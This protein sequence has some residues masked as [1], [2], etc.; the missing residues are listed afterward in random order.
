MLGFLECVFIFCFCIERPRQSDCIYEPHSTDK[1]SGVSR[2]L[3]AHTGTSTLE[4]L[5][6][7][8]ELASCA[9]S[10]LAFSSLFS[11]FLF[12]KTDPRG[13]HLGLETLRRWGKERGDMCDILPAAPYSSH[14]FLL[15]PS[16]L[17]LLSSF[18]KA[19]W[20]SCRQHYHTDQHNPT[21]LSGNVLYLF[22]PIQWPH[23]QRIFRP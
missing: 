10:C 9:Y 23:G 22:C 11:D 16:L 18:N 5:Q 21:E 15:F 7:G 13:S 3:G 20:G 17:A 14:P 12:S 6:P 4:F 19:C 8:G 1:T 2:F